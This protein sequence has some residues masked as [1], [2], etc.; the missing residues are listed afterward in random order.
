M[1]RVIYF[2]L[3]NN[4]TCIFANFPTI[5][6]CPFSAVFRFVRLIDGVHWSYFWHR[7]RLQIGCL[8]PVSFQFDL[9]SHILILVK[10]R[11]WGKL[12]SRLCHFCVSSETVKAWDDGVLNLHFTTSQSRA[13]KK[14][15]WVIWEHLAMKRN[16]EP[17]WW[18]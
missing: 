17:E 3:S 18:Q 12:S 14:R 1:L 15:S 7:H 2:R 9:S 16:W 4:R 13:E 8:V 6:N 11:S 5:S 10:S